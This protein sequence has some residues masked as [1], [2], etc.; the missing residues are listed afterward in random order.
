MAVSVNWRALLKGIRRAPLKGFG[1]IEERF[2][3][4]L[5]VS[6]NWGCFWWVSFPEERYYFRVHIGAPGSKKLP[7]R[8]VQ[9]L[10]LLE[11]RSRSP[12][13]TRPNLRADI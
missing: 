9:K 8:H 13:F 12:F 5:A 6:T 10:R 3:V 2:R 1:S 7:C 4:D 11:L